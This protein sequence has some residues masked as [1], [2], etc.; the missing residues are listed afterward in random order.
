MSKIKLTL[1][2]TDVLLP[3]LLL[4]PTSAPP[5]I[6]RLHSAYRMEFFQT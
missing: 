6:T 4:R 3:L 2:A 5:K 1:G